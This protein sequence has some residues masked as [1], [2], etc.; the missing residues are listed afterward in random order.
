MHTQD[1]V[2]PSDKYRD[3]MQTILYMVSSIH[4]LA[5][6]VAYS[7][8]AMYSC[9]TDGLN[10]NS[11]GTFLGNILYIFGYLVYIIGEY[12]QLR[13]KSQEEHRLIA[14]GKNHDS[15]LFRISS[16]IFAV[17]ATLYTVMSVDTCYTDGWT[18]SNIGTLIGNAIYTI[19]CIIYSCAEYVYASDTRTLLMTRSAMPI[20]Q[21]IEIRGTYGSP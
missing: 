18:Q 13:R 20:L 11:I 8:V 15:K 7:Y 10:F 2:S 6:S 16:A 3:R 21:H 4:L 5:S 9:L 14:K 19:G 17:S 1:A 12:I